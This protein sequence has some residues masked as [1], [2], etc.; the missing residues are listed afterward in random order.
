[1]ESAGG[2]IAVFLETYS[3]FFLADI[4]NR[5]WTTIIT[6]LASDKQDLLQTKFKVWPLSNFDK[7]M[8]FFTETRIVSV[9]NLHEHA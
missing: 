8:L 6:F 7:Y 1:M 4:S 2:T 9:F 3:G 5:P